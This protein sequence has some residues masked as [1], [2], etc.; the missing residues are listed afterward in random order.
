MPE[1]KINFVCPQCLAVN[2]VPDSRRGDAPICGKCKSKLIPDYPVDL[3]ATNFQSV[4]SKSGVVVVVDFWAAWCGPCRMM[5]PAFADAA[6]ILSPDFI[7]AKLDTDQFSQIASP[8]NISGIPCLIAFRNGR[9]TARQSG[10]MTT[11]Q[12]V[13]WVRSV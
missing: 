7:L 10:V 2:K 4:I 11:D 12:I 1:S 8:F 5:A 9:E 3:N 6:K 13:Q